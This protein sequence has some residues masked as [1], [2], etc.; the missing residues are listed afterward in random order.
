MM[1][2]TDAE[3]PGEVI[4]DVAGDGRRALIEFRNQARNNALSIAMWGQ[5]KEI[6]ERLTPMPDL[7]VVVL[8]G[9]GRRAFCAGADI[10]DFDDKRSGDAAPA[11]DTLVEDTCR[12]LDEF[13]V[14]SVAMIHGFCMG[15]GLSIASCC[16]LRFCDP[17][18]IFALPAA[19]LGLGYTRHGIE[20]L[21][22]VVGLPQTKRILFT[23]GRIDSDRAQ[24]IGLTHDIVDADILEST[25]AA[26]VDDIC[27]NAPL[28]MRAMKLCMTE[29]AK[30]PT[31]RDIDAC[32]AAIRRCNESH[33]Y[34]EGRRAFAE[35]RPPV[36]KGY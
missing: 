34:A 26:L 31:A 11:Y 30:D 16:D 2:D 32:L 14:P 17:S 10:R 23:A 7:R 3:M 4:V 18:A 15:A 12:L 24:S 21:I 36:F 19:R 35:K 25:V 20:R 9:A 33:D 1:T 27:R 28:T 22:R 8:R 13:P 5:L 6:L 29:M